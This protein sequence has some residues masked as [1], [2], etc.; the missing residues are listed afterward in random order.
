M[1]VFLYI[2]ITT[3]TVVSSSCKTTKKISTA[4]AKKDTAQAVKVVNAHEDSIKFIKYAFSKLQQNKIDFKTFSGKIKVD[5]WDKDGKGP[6]LTVFLRMKKDSIIWLSIN[7]SLLSIEVFR[8]MITPDSVKVLN[9]KDKEV[10]FRSVSYIQE[11][12]H[13]PFDFKTLQDIFIGNPVYLD[14][15]IVSYKKDVQATT[16]LSIGA[17]F[18]NLVTLQN[19][20]YHLMHS[21]LDDVDAM[22]N[23]T[24]DLVYGDYQNNGGVKFA[25]SRN[26][27][28]SE[29][30]KLEV[31]L[32][33]KQYSF[34]E[35]LEYPFN[36]PK[37]YKKK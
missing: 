26:V 6:D 16:L 28:V 24:C 31:H 36:I 14:S 25:A 33:F 19:D 2:L 27:T 32:D 20:D 5:Y 34:N 23:R 30:A 17:L 4:I 13:L 3:L 37:N 15:N 8:V 9:K 12:A 21:K 7:A 1:K 22:R 18:K 29:K 35:N 10:Q 11:V